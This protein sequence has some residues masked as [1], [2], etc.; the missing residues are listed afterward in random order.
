[1]R[2]R[3]TVPFRPSVPAG[4]SAGPPSFTMPRYVAFLRAINVGGHTVTMDRLRALFGDLGVTGIETFIASGNVVFES[5]SRSPRT[6]ES[7]I[8]RHLET[9]LGYGVATFVRTTRDVGRIA[10]ATPFGPSEAGS[11]PSRIYVGLLAAEP[12]AGVREALIALS[13]PT[14]AF[15]VDGRELY[16]LCRTPFSESPFSGA[17]LERTL[18]MPATIR[19]VTTIRRI[20]EKWA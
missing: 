4:E 17:S 5:P 18:G 19:S 8:A 20:A 15:E 10:R 3:T 11:P 6:L 13:T 12:P 7:A 16:W 9:H 1:M 2:R 14:D